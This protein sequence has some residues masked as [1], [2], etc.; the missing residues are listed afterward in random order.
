MK[1]VIISLAILFFFGT[2]VYLANNYLFVD[3]VKTAD[4][5]CTP[6]C[7]AGDEWCTCKGKCE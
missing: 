6:H 7:Q 5:P 1:T 4:C 3:N 2:G